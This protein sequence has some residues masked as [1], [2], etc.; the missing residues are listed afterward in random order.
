MTDSTQLLAD[1]VRALAPDA[2]S[3]KAGEGLATARKW[4]S[5]GRNDQVL[6]GQIKG[7]GSQPYQTRI[8]LADFTVACTCP[9]RKLPC[10]HALG[11]LLLLAHS[12][13][14]VPTA[15]I[16]PFV[17]EW[18][19]KRAEKIANAE[20]K[21]QAKQEEVPI[22]AKA[23]ADAAKRE[24]TRE[25]RMAEG[26]DELKRW[27]H[28]LTREGFTAHNL[29]H[30]D[31]WEQ[32]AKRLNDAQLPGLA[33][34]MQEL[35]LIAVTR[36]S[37]LPEVVAGLGLINLALAACQNQSALTTL[38][39]Y[40]L[41]RF[42]GVAQR[43]TDISIESHLADD[44]LCLGERIENDGQLTT[45]R[46]WLWGTQSQRPALLLSFAVGN[47]SLTAGPMPQQTYSLTLGFYPSNAPLRAALISGDLVGVNTLI[48]PSV[49]TIA[50][51]LRKV[52]ERMGRDPWTRLFPLLISARLGLDDQGR[53]WLAD[54]SGDALPI[55]SQR[56]PYEWL[57][58]S[59]GEETGWFGEWNGTH[60]QLLGGWRLC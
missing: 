18:L 20:K 49:E 57:A 56:S 25:K 12:P 31:I 35:G 52:A 24:A 37:W 53:W 22:S 34:R 17:Q 55:V 10:K 30:P 45:R 47:Q 48:P 28:D 7:S 13:Q 59:Q 54:T 3:V 51:A 21:L 16:P 1:Q 27:L 32:R 40:D 29:R 50:A 39:R 43:E 33:R 4:I 19:N 44:W 58:F 36:E 26:L 14:D 23:Q 9:S 38:E 60:F 5:I 11:L 41:Q 46:T 2:S 42:L 8:W 15:D 6:W